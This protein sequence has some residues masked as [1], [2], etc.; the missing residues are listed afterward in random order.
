MQLLVSIF[1]FLEFWLLLSGS[2]LTTVRYHELFE[3]VR[4]RNFQVS[5]L[6]EIVMASGIA[7][8]ATNTDQGLIVSSE[9]V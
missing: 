9:N 4:C 2:L 7:K 5:C 1:H 8:S 6:I 3:I